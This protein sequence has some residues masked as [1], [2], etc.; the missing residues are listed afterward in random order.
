MYF[1][2]VQK[3]KQSQSVFQPHRDS[4]PNPLL[5]DLLAKERVGV[6]PTIGM[7]NMMQASQQQQPV[8]AAGAA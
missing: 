4:R 8:Y 5:V 7:A 2:N 3:Y 1:E 6:Q